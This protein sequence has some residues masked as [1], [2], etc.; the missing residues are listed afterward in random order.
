MTIFWRKGGRSKERGRQSSLRRKD[1]L[2]L[3]LA[4]VLGMLVLVSLLGR[5]NASIG[6]FEFELNT[7]FSLKGITQLVIPPFG[8]DIC[9]Y[10]YTSVEVGSPA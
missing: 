8:Q 5:M 6:P 10:S 2:K 7:G 9:H 1:I 3:L 4:S